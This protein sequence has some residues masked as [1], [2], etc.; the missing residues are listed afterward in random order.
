MIFSWTPTT[1]LFSCVAVTNLKS[2]RTQFETPVKRAAELA[3]H[4]GACAVHTELYKELLE[5]YLMGQ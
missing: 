4:V 1:S 5:R 3:G 2:V